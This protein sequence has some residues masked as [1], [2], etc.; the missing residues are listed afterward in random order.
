MNRSATNPDIRASAVL[1]T[2]RALPRDRPATIGATCRAIPTLGDHITASDSSALATHLP[3]FFAHVNEIVGAIAT[4]A[5]LAAPGRRQGPSRN[6]KT[7][8]R[9]RRFLAGVL[10][11]PN[12]EEAAPPPDA[13]ALGRATALRAHWARAFAAPEVS[14]PLTRALVADLSPAVDP[15]RDPHDLREYRQ[16]TPQSA[17]QRSKIEN[18]AELGAAAR[19]AA[20]LSAAPPPLDAGDDDSPPPSPRRSSTTS[21]RLSCPS[22]SP[23]CEPPCGRW[24]SH[25]RSASSSTRHHHR[26]L[27]VPK[28]TMP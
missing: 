4:S 8:T 15:L 14:G 9:W 24:A 5:T 1:Q 28:M 10:V 2:S 3:G 19:T 20:C 16:R 17:A 22:Q 27:Q 21:R 26:R 13:S 25:D 18:A 6:D 23:T 7:S 11:P 12:L